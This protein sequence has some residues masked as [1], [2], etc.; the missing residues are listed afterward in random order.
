MPPPETL[1]PGGTYHPNY[2]FVACPDYKPAEQLCRPVWSIPKQAIVSKETY[3]VRNEELAKQELG[4]SYPAHLRILGS[5]SSSGTVWATGGVR[6][7][8]A[9]SADLRFVSVPS[10]RRYQHRVFVGSGRRLP[11]AGTRK[12][13][14]WRVEP[15]GVVYV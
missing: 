11:R 3:E 6:A 5:C 9:I 15:D 10:T 8:P 13:P 4:N 2:L 12:G 1:S 14:R 7:R